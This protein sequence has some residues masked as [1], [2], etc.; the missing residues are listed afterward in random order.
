M[1]QLVDA[2]ESVGMNAERL[3]R[4]RPVMQRYVDQNGYAGISTMVARR[5]KIVYSD[6]VGWQDKEAGVAMADDTIFR[7]YSMTKPIIYTA[8]MTL[9][10]EGKFSLLDPVAK[11]I[12]AFAAT[13][14][15]QGD[16]SLADQNPL[17]PIQVRDLMTHCSGL[18]YDFLED[19]PVGQMYREARLMNDATRTLEGVIDELA[20]IPLAFHPGSQWHY[21][22]GTDVAAH[23]IQVIS[24]QPLGQFLQERMFRPLG[25]EDTAF[26]VSPEKRSRLAA[27]YGLPDLFE[28][29]M[30]FSALFGHFASGNS[31]RR[32][33]ADTYP[34]DTPDVFLRGGIGLFSTAADYTRFATM[35]LTGKAEDGTRIIG[36][37]T[38]ELMH[39]NHL[40]AELLPYSIA[41]I[42]TLGYGFG[43]GSRVCSD[44]GATAVAGSAGE[45]GWAGAAKTYYWVDPREE[46]VGVFMTQYMVGFDLPENDLRALVYQAIED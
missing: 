2:P 7:I 31:G 45:F 24:G 16:G 22:L 43:L 40:P 11:F 41:G 10:E 26:G 46:L 30:T 32:E 9:Y 4:I 8:L 42:P 38:L 5:G 37:K 29:G 44:I 12:P 1:T 36:R 33:V 35:L 21:S 34:V 18:S 19:F 17:R 28:Q 3:E 39:T 27:M 20:R 25:M 13:K 23:L 14:V 15:L 6:Q